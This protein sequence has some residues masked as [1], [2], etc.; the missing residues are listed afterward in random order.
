MVSQSS[1]SFQSTVTD[2]NL[3]R[4][5]S[6]RS[7]ISYHNYASSTSSFSSIAS[8]SASL[9]RT[10]VP[11]YNLQA[12]N[13]MT[14]LIVDAGTDAK[15]AKFQRRGIILIDLVSLEP[16]EVWGD[17]S[18]YTGRN[19]VNMTVDDHQS[20]PV[21]NSTFSSTP[22]VQVHAPTRH[23]NANSSAISLHSVKRKSAD[24]SYLNVVHT[25]PQ[26]HSPQPTA[27]S[28]IGTD[29]TPTLPIPQPQSPGQT[30]RS[31]FGK[32]FQTGSNKKV[33]V[34]SDASVVIS[35]PLQELPQTTP[36]PSYQQTHGFSVSTR[37]SEKG[38]T[39]NTS[40]TTLAT[41]LKSVLKNNKPK[42]SRIMGSSSSSSSN[43]NNSLEGQGVGLGI[44]SPGVGEKNLPSPNMSASSLATT[45]EGVEVGSVIHNPSSATPQVLL[46]PPTHS[47]QQSPCS[48][49]FQTQLQQLQ[50]RPPVLGI[51]PTYVSAL[52][53]SSLLCPSDLK[54]TKAL[55]YVWLVR[56]WLKRSN[57]HNEHGLSFSGVT[58]R[59]GIFSGLNAKGR[60]DGH[61]LHS[62]EPGAGFEVRFEWKRGKVKGSGR[63]RRG[64]SGRRQSLATMR[65]WDDSEG[66]E[67][68]HL[69]SVP[70]DKSL[71]SKLG[72]KRLSSSSAK[73][74]RSIGNEV[75][76]L[77]PENG[78]ETPR[79]ASGQ[80]KNAVV[81]GLDV[82]ELAA[83]GGVGRDDGEESDPEDSETPW[84]CTLKIKRTVPSFSTS[85][86]RPS[87]A[88]KD[89][90]E[91]FLKLKVGTLSPMPHHP[92]VVAMLK[93]PFPLPDVEVERL[94]LRRRVLGSIPGQGGVNELGET[95][96][97]L[98]TPS[99]S[100]QE[101]KYRGL[102][103]SAE[104]LKDIV[105]STALWLIVRQGTGGVGRVSRKGDG[106]KLRS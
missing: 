55:M 13:V 85:N 36:R 97:P 89:S 4:C 8:S 93:V 64:G 6:L 16:V 32:L 21:Q 3:T 48:A 102:E 5:S 105:C 1:A 76:E 25:Q 47:H 60:E 61:N 75:G 15:I 71:D 65:K 88:R 104:E 103:L 22:P 79:R 100:N 33:A 20:S 50:S 95:R 39:R 90:G 74:G 94:N 101:D 31:I 42:L 27:F 70:T 49:M 24:S 69:R 72:H 10:I 78:E 67:D 80:P 54:K 45:N 106:W 41:P 53:S 26:H 52:G 30:K 99:E 86:G 92:K 83:D 23:L 87:Q 43:V 7:N 44:P 19:S 35:Q 17:V 98:L 63:G 68:P 46:H 59:G 38:H 58:S 82:S 57:H 2:T 28:A 37:K 77:G 96:L 66:P 73:S 91:E 56:K 62:D 34:V 81:S 12:H 40:L 14:N 11:L 84:V 18:S 9:R 51:Q 29:S